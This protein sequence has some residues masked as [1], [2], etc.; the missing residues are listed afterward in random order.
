VHAGRI[1]EEQLL[2]P[3]RAISVGSHARSTI[4]L[5]G[6][7]QSERVELFVVRGSR[8][9]LKLLPGA[10]GKLS[11]DGAVRTLDSLA[12]DGAT[13]RRGGELL[14]P[15]A[16]D[17]RGKVQF[18]DYTLLFQ[19][20]EP[21]PQATSRGGGVAW[22]W[23][24]VDWIFMGLVA[25]S[26]LVHV[27]AVAWIEAQPPPTRVELR[28]LVHQ[29]VAFTIAAPEADVPPEPPTQDAPEASDN[30][31]VDEGP[32]VP[33]PASEHADSGPDSSSPDPG[34][35]EV[36]HNPFAGTFVELI[37]HALDD[38]NSS[39]RGLI[40]DGSDYKDIGEALASGEVRIARERERPGLRGPSTIGD[41]VASIG[42]LGP[43]GDC[44]DCPARP[45]RRPDREPVS[46]PDFVADPLPAPTTGEFDIR[47][48]LKRLHPQFK[49][50]YEKELKLVPDLSGRVSLSFAVDG[51]ARVVEA[52]IE[53][54]S[55]RS[56]GLGQCVI[57]KL[58]RLSL[59]AEAS[60]LEV[61]DYGLMFAP[62]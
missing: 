37:G 15:L 56:A 44:A 29:H 12:L 20:V 13:V 14:Y 19:L 41:D 24:D 61:E 11:V 62:Q 40:D 28:E 18:R 27:A 6:E 23:R 21:P 30:P 35:T 25:I 55:T 47:P 31:T 58:N 39:V 45:S 60:D 33:T 42:V 48:W 34:E 49:A 32:P 57:K 38:P 8:L 5:P 50:C 16:D 22:S 36:A 51:S 46:K 53:S 9:H 54:N 52:R 2:P 26:A 7:D 4:L 17:A 10:R 59:P 3:G 1:V 43:A